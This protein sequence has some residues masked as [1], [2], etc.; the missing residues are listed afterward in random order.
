MSNK[1]TNFVVPTKEGKT[2]AEMVA[3]VLTRP[4]FNAAFSLHNITRNND[5][6][7]TVNEFRKALDESCKEVTDGDLSRLEHMLTSQAIVLDQL[8]G[9]LLRRSVRNMGE[10]MGAAD[11]Y[12]RLA[13]KAQSQARQTIET[14]ALV[15]NPMPYIRQA[16]IG[17]N[18]QVNNG[19]PSSPVTTH[20][21]AH[22]GKNE[23]PPN[24][25][26]AQQPGAP[27]TGHVTADAKERVA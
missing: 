5:S 3:D 10:Y 18:V 14:L 1:T 25:L 4:Q 27:I 17:Q 13:L 6:I 7:V 12:M 19:K 2:E 21:H 15:K 23:N 11:T 8:F 16:N 20:A 9:D 22:A 26:L 24:E